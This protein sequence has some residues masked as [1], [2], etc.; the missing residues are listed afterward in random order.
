MASKLTFILGGARSGKSAYA[1]QMAQAAGDRILYI[2]TARVFDEE[3]ERRVAA[4]RA[5]RPVGW[6]TLE[7]PDHIVAGL[8]SA[9]GTYNAIL[10]DCVTLLLGESFLPLPE[11]ANE[12][13]LTNAAEDSLE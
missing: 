7:L 12:L 8:E 1:Q 6:E 2:A 11:D 3:M 9:T 5:S 13:E 10:L 4:H